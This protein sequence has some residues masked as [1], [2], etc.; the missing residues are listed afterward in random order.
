MNQLTKMT[1]NHRKGCLRSPF[2]E[3]CFGLACFRRG[4]LLIQANPKLWWFALPSII[5]YLPVFFLFLSYFPTLVIGFARGAIQT[6]LP[7]WSS[8]VFGIM[9]FVSVILISAL[10]IF[11]MLIIVA[12]FFLIATIVA[13]IFNDV[14]SEKTEIIYIGTKTTRHISIKRIPRTYLFII[15][16][17]FK[18]I[19]FY[20]LIQ[21]L[22]FLFNIIPI[23]GQLIYSVLGGI[24]T[25]Y[26]IGFEYVDYSLS[27]RLMP[28][29]KKWKLCL[30]YKWRIFG[31]GMA[32]SLLLLIPLLNVVIMSIAVI[33]ATLIAID[34]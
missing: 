27:R 17:E 5:V 21:C 24:F 19:G 22:L 2:S 28:F 23:I 10:I 33:G 14:L 12:I 6:I 9:A 11:W 15:G 3:F 7:L 34:L 18:K 4:C 8:G 16:V 20:L 31:Y 26:F 25:I 1:L 32:V 13:S 29:R 30:F